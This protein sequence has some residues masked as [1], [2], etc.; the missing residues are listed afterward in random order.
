MAQWR[1]FP[2]L[3]GHCLGVRG[4]TVSIPMAFQR[5]SK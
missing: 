3:P 2:C 5:A 4:V 1:G